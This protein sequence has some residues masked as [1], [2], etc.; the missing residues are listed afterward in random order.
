[1]LT[2]FRDT[3]AEFKR[4]VWLETLPVLMWMLGRNEL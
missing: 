2:N 4:L 3:K 1:M